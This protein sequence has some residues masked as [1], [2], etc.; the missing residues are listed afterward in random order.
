MYADPEN[1]QDIVK[2]IFRLKTIQEVMDKITSLYPTFICSKLEEYSKDYP[3]FDINWR[4]MCMTLK[5]KK[6]HILLVDEVPDDDKHILINSFCEILTQSGFIIRKS[7]EFFPCSVCCC[8]IPSENIY[9]KLKELK[10]SVP[11]KWNK[12]CVDCV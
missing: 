11:E 3:H 12:H 4:G 9:N 1:S 2:D 6:A 8:A 10:I 7:S 5:V